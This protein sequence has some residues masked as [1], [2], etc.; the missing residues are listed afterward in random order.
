MPRQQVHVIIK[1]FISVYSFH[2]QG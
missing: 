1:Q 2:P